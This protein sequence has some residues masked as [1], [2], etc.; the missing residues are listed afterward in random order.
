MEGNENLHL[1]AAA[2]RKG[3]DSREDLFAIPSFVLLA[4][5][6]VPLCFTPIYTI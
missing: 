1:P 3:E 2:L 4:A 6:L 5:F